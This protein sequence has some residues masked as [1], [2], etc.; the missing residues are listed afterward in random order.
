MSH[1]QV[2]CRSCD[3]SIDTSAKFCPECGAITQ[4]NPLARLPAPKSG[5]IRWGWIGVIGAVA[6]G[7][8]FVAALRG[9]RFEQAGGPA[10]GPPVEEE[11]RIR[12]AVRSDIDG[13]TITNT[14]GFDYEDITLTLNPGLLSGYKA[15]ISYLQ[16]GQSRKIALAEFADSDNTRFN[17]FRTKLERVSVKCRARS[18]LGFAEFALSSQ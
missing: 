2:K 3:T 7:W 9:E 14:D 8:M 18:R 15:R 11:I 1:F 10:A 5:Q 16:S 12:P 4:A 17:I 6:L 13:L